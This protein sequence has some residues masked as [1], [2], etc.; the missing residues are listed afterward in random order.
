MTARRATVSAVAAVLAAALLVILL[1]TW[2]AS[3]GPSGVLRGDGIEANRSAQPSAS[4]STPTGTERV[5]D[6]DRVAQ[7]RPDG[8]N[9]VIRTIAFLVE[10]ATACLVLYLL[11]RLAGWL[12]QVYDAR[13]RR[14]PRAE[15]VDFEVIDA[16][17][18]VAR[19]VRGGADEQRL[20]LQTGGMPGDA[21]IACWHRFE[22]QAEAAGMSR[23][24]AETSSEFTLRILG[25]IDADRG[26]V[27][28]LGRLYR[29]A[30][31]SGHEM[32]E[33]DRA[34]AVEALDL[35]HR[36]LMVAS[37]RGRS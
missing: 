31:F 23:R 21:I 28:R 4:L 37:G 32:T 35:L 5:S 9:P 24:P 27:T 30:R 25:L 29:E 18:A 14:D 36:G 33:A 22:T 17:A 16:P 6:R 8:A 15:E 10:I 34:A 12:R 20:L 11:F 7:S 19:E 2:A 3:I 13:R 1:V 26:A